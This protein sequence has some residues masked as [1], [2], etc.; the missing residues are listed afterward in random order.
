MKKD[1]KWQMLSE[2]SV[3]QSENFITH[4]FEGVK[5]IPS[6]CNNS[7][8]SEKDL[9]ADGGMWIVNKKSG[10]GWKGVQDDV[11]V[12]RNELAPLWVKFLAQHSAGKG[13]ILNKIPSGTALI[14]LLEKWHQ[15][16]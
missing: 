12:M 2:L 5:G 9:K 11:R 4:N 16:L 1:E 15:L 6:W 7:F 8:V 10:S 14:E 3:E 13:G